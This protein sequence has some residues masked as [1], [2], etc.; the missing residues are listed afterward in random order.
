MATQST[1]P[2]CVNHQFESKVE[3]PKNSNYPLQM[4]RCTSCGCVVGVLEYYNLGYMLDKIAAALN[5]KV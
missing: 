4:I 5:V 3:T 1:C 2:K